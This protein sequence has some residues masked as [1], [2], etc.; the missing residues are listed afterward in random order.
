V[1]SILSEVRGFRA[2][3]FGVAMV[4][5]I[6]CDDG[7]C[8]FDTDCDGIRIC[9][10]ER[11]VLRDPPDGGGAGDAGG[12][13]AV[14]DGAAPDGGPDAGMPFRRGDIFASTRV[15]QDAGSGRI[16]VRFR[17]EPG[18]PAPCPF[19]PVPD[20]EHCVLRACEPEPPMDAGMPDAGTTDGGTDL[21]GAVADAGVAP[22][23]NAGGIEVARGD[24]S[25][26]TTLVPDMDGT[27]ALYTT[28]GPLWSSEGAFVF[29]A[30]GAEVPAFELQVELPAPLRVT[31]P[32]SATLPI[33]LT[34]GD[35]VAVS[36]EGSTVGELLFRVRTLDGNVI[37][38]CS[39]D[40]S[41]ASPPP[42][43]GDALASFPV[44]DDI[45]L[46]VSVRTLT[47][48]EAGVWDLRGYAVA[49]ARRPNDRPLSGLRVDLQPAP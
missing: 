45:R 21:D 35:D 8:R 10:E 27:Y 23:A 7:E 13:G 36:W 19:E 18:A 1:R 25:I 41:M 16:R 32:D 49:T 20:A 14:M 30:D 22:M 9:V 15:D 6:G 42:L 5:A 33:V 43:P 47:R 28:D 12:D 24:E 4:A 39:Y 11:C 26:V 46:D 44:G 38:Q 40:P 48:E 17:T 37:L 34:Q 3:A 31:S 2:A 29:S